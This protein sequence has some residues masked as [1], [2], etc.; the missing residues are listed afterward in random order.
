MLQT[1]GSVIR[2][3]YHGSSKDQAMIA[4]RLFFAVSR[5]LRDNFSDPSR[6]L[7]H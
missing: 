5:H 2:G 7:Q 3:R 4:I 1:R 6:F